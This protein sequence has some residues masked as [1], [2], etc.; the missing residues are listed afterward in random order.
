MARQLQRSF[1]EIFNS[2]S[3]GL[4]V[5]QV[6]DVLE[7]RTCVYDASDWWSCAEPRSQGDRNGEEKSPSSSESTSDDGAEQLIPFWILHLLCSI[8]TRHLRFLLPQMQE[9]RSH[10]PKRLHTQQC[11]CSILAS[12]SFTGT[13]ATSRKHCCS[14]RTTHR[15]NNLHHR[16]DLMPAWAR[17]AVDLPDR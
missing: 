10:T 3:V 7:S 6:W 8:G 12:V 5:T 14:T 13:S 4:C 15:F 1:F 11:P 9:Q 17:R 2:L 16:S